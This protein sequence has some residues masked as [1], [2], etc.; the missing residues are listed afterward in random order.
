MDFLMV[1][2]L[3][4]LITFSGVAF[5]VIM[6]AIRNVEY[7]IDVLS[8]KDTQKKLEQELDRFE[9]KMPKPTFYE[10]VTVDDRK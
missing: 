10:P 2:M 3:V 5:L 4:I 9:H 6:N 7:S 8:A 1:A